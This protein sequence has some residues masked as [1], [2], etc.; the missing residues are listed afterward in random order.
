MHHGVRR[1]I[2]SI[3][4][5]VSHQL[6]V[7]YLCFVSHFVEFILNCLIDVSINCRVAEKDW[8]ADFRKLSAG[9]ALVGLTLWLDHMQASSF[10]LL[11]PLM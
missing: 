7:N 1:A 2:F 5:S 10:F 8:G 4:C 9:S 6:Y 3:G 11:H